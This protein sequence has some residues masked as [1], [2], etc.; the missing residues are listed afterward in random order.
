VLAATPGLPGDLWVGSR[1]I[2]LY[3]STDGGAS[4]TKLNNVGGADA[5]GF[6]K[7]APGKMFP[8]LYLLGSINQLQACY[9][10]DDAGQTWVRI[11]DDQHRFGAPDRPLIIG[12]PRIYGRVY[13]T[14]GGRGVIYGDQDPVTR[15]FQRAS[16]VPRL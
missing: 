12:D 6:G 3:H 2:G 10:S 4:F 9:R 15:V 5:L 14:T 1:N 11:N 8:A 7:A 13:L 16:S